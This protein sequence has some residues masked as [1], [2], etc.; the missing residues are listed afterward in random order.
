V[1]APSFPDPSATRLETWSPTTIA[2]LRRC[3]L[4]QAFS[5]DPIWKGLARPTTHS[6]LGTATHALA[7]AAAK[8]EIRATPPGSLEDAVRDRWRSLLANGYK[9]LATAWSPA[10]VPLPESWRNYN[11]ISTRALRRAFRTIA[12]SHASQL[13]ASRPLVPN[14][15]A[16]RQRNDK[17]PI[18]PLASTAHQTWYKSKQ[19]TCASLISRQV[20]HRR[21]RLPNRGFNFCSMHI[22]SAPLVVAYPMSAPSLMAPAASTTF[23]SPNPMSI[24]WCWTLSNSSTVSTRL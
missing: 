13:P 8:A 5:Q 17:S 24:K 14:V 3:G 2:R 20:L 1:T 7:E 15:H 16:M 10:V 6:V 19:V 22:L 12:E 11:V 21:S 9:K 23:R 18:R 4:A